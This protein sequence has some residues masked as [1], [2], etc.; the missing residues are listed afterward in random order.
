MCKTIPNDAV[1]R[2]LRQGGAVFECESCG[3]RMFVRS[4]SG[5]CPMCWNGRRPIAMEEPARPVAE[6]MCLAGILDDP[7]IESEPP[8]SVPLLETDPTLGPRPIL[9]TDEG[10]AEPDLE[11]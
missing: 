10:E 5:L 4:N 11:V 7:A 6:G 1:V 2:A 9:E 8:G 3:E